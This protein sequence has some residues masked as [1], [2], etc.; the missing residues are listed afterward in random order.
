M[1][2]QHGGSRPVTRPDDG[3]RNN[4]GH[5]GTGPKPKSFALKLD[6]GYFVHA[7]TPE[8]KQYGPSMAWIV[9]EVGRDY[10]EVTDHDTGNV[11]RIVRP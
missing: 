6:S 4:G 8:G 2:N 5:K 11:Y 10:I 9:T 7:R 3:R 1:T